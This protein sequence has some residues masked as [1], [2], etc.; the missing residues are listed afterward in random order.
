MNM[1]HYLDYTIKCINVCVC[2]NQIIETK[3]KKH[4]DPNFTYSDSEIALK[5]CRNKQTFKFNYSIRIRKQIQ[6]KRNQKTIKEA[7]E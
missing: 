6:K 1:E 7:E 2:N 3:K 4:I 5:V